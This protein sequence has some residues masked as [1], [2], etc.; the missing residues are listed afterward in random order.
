MFTDKSECLPRSEKNLHSRHYTK[1][2][3]V[4]LP[5][6][7]LGLVFFSSFSFPPPSSFLSETPDTVHYWESI[8]QPMSVA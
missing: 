2:S 1:F 3:I 5:Q 4:L 6:F 7:I 8:L